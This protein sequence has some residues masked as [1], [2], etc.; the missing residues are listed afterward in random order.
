MKSSRLEENKNIE[1]NIIK[2]VR[3]LFR[4]RKLKKRNKVVQGH[5]KSLLNR[6]QNDLEKMMKGSEF[7]S[8]IIIFQ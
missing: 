6:Y 4:L 3:N 1:E 5:F 7:G 8:L 2:D